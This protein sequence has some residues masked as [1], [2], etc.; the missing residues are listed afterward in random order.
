MFEAI[1]RGAPPSNANDAVL[2]YLTRWNE[3]LWQIYPNRA[4]HGRRT[5]CSAPPPRLIRS[6]SCRWRSRPSRTSAVDLDIRGVAHALSVDE[7]RIVTNGLA[8][9]QVNGTSGID[10]FY[11]TPG[12]HIFD[13]GAGADNY[14]VGENSGNDTIIDYGHQDTNQLI[15]TSVKA[16]D[17]FATREGEDLLIKINGSDS[18]I[19]VK[20]QFLGELNPLFTDGTRQTSGIDSILFSDGTI[21]DRF[22]MAFQVAHPAD[23]DDPIIGS[24]SADVIWGG[25]GN[26][27]LSG[28]AGGDIY[29]Y[30]RGDGQD[31]IDDQGAFSFGPIKA[32]LDFLAFKGGITPDDL[33]LTR[34]GESD[35]LKITLLDSEGNPTTDTLLI[36]GAF[37]GLV[38]NLQA[39]GR[40][41]GLDGRA[42]L[43]RSQPDREVHFRR[44]LCARL[45]ADY[46][47]RHREPE[48]R[49]A[50]T[51]SM[52]SSTTI[53]SMAA[54]AMIT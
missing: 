38:L 16:A 5:I 18:V 4:A 47:D 11:I 39:F 31:V 51:R 21:W 6:S 23:T 44:R 33:K 30:Q 26:D 43:R 13:G 7:T 32:G 36:K 12:D 53:L 46:R 41:H 27:F 9:T 17:V 8:D 1:F 15:F 37:D 19:R 35:D 52:G 34:E 14:F 2:D 20:D 42:C 22:R 54:P 10:Y 48:N 29:I 50:T 3:I 45:H 28:G 49:Q 40:A 25:K 24:G